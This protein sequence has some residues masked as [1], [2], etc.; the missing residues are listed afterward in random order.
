[1]KN[2]RKQISV[3]LTLWAAAMMVATGEPASPTPASPA[4]GDAEKPKFE[5]TE[6]EIKLP[7]VTINRATREV[8]IAA[9]VCLQSGILEYVVC[10]PDTFEHEAIFTTE[11]KPELVHAAL[12]LCGLK[13]TPQLRGLSDLWSEKVMKQEQSRVKIEVEWE[14]EGVRKRVN[15]ISMLQD[16]QDITMGVEVDAQSKSKK[17]SQVQDAW[18]FAGSFLQENKETGKRFYAA[19]SSGIL[20]GIWPNPS[21]VI[22]YGLTSGDPHKGKHQ[23]LE[24]YEECVPKVGTKVKLVFSKHTVSTKKEDTGKKRTSS[25]TDEIL[26]SSPRIMKHEIL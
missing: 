24:I 8:R 12:L 19:N 10:R 20:V 1:M 18:V 26:H 15:L 23:G 6:T 16:R 11:A 5:V 25:T 9:E 13:P 2:H 4:P 7:G 3:G 14:L 17:E 21:T 22:Q